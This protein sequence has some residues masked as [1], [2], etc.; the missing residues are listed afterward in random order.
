MKETR[1]TTTLSPAKW[2]IT[3]RGLCS[4]DLIDSKE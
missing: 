1:E 4:P 3:R 2:G